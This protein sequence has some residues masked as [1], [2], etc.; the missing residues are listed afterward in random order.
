MVDFFS[1]YRDSTTNS[2]SR[3]AVRR[4]AVHLALVAAKDTV[5]GLSPH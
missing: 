1:V 2:E 5:R 4:V 3:D